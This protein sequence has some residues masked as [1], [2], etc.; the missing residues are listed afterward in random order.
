[1]DSLTLW[2][3]SG[4]TRSVLHRAM[5]ENVLCLLD[6]GEKRVL[7]WD[8]DDRSWL[9]THAAG[10]DPRF[11]AAAAIDVDA[12][13]LD[14]FPAF[15]GR[16]AREVT[17]RRGDC[18]YIPFQWYHQVNSAAGRNLAVNFWWKPTASGAVSLARAR[19]RCC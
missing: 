15:K 14:L 13:D 11:G 5:S 10:W 6:G 9:E 1:M 2:F 3:S 8:R 19:A 7:L 12:I 17:L 16:A 4:G 18:L